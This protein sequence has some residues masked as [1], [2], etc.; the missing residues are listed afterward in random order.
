MSVVVF[1]VWSRFKINDLDRT[2]AFTWLERQSNSGKSF[3]FV[4]SRQSARLTHKDVALGAA[5]FLSSKRQSK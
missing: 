4:L 5:V 3:A 2:Q 1:G